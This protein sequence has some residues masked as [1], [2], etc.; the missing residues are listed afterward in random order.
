MFF[1]WNLILKIFIYAIVN[2]LNYMLSCTQS[3]TLCHLQSCHIGEEDEGGEQEGEEPSFEVRQTEMVWGTR[4]RDTGESAEKQ[5]PTQWPHQD[6]TL[7]TPPTPTFLFHL[8]LSFCHYFTQT[9]FLFPAMVDWPVHAFAGPNSRI[10]VTDLFLLI[11][12]IAWLGFREMV[13]QKTTKW[14][15]G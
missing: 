6:I 10:N 4:G 8:F 12:E 15:P 2:S 5:L 1:L 13:K 14:N 7:G 9:T 3:L 11:C